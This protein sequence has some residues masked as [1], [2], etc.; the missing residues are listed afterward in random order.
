MSETGALPPGVMFTDKGDGTATLSGTPAAGSGRTYTFTITAT[1]VAGYDTQSF[2]LTVNEACK[3][4]SL[5][6]TT[7]TLTVG[8]AWT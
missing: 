8:F 7:T 5:P 4:T 3:I 2:I 1:N 6:P